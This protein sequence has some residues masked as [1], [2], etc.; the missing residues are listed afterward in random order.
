MGNDTKNQRNTPVPT[1]DLLA[2]TQA[3]TATRE[4]VKNVTSKLEEVAKDARKASDGVITLTG[5]SKDITRRVGSLESLPEAHCLHEDILSEHDSRL[6]NTEKTTIDHGKAITAH[7]K[8]M[9]GLTTWRTWLTTIAATVIMAVAG[10]AGK[11]IWDTATS[12]AT[13]TQNTEDIDELEKARIADRDAIIRAVK[14]VPTQVEQRIPA[15]APSKSNGVDIEEVSSKLRPYQ[16]R[17]LKQLLE[18]AG[19]Q[20]EE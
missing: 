14:A 3:V 15:A 2:L 4:G 10:A 6:D 5:W 7:E 12:R 9:A 19:V 17:Q 8:E 11:A 20:T 13:I 1:G 16:R 18:Q